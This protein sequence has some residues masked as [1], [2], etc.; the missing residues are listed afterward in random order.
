MSTLVNLDPALG[1]TTSDTWDPPPHIEY[2][3]QSN[4]GS[5]GLSGTPF[6]GGYTI[7]MP[8]SSNAFVTLETDVWVNYWSQ[9]D[10]CDF[11]DIGSGHVKVLDPS[12]WAITFSGPVGFFTESTSTLPTIVTVEF[13][14]WKDPYITCGSAGPDVVT[15]INAAVV[16]F[17]GVTKQTL[18]QQQTQTFEAAVGPN[19]NP[20]EINRQC[21]LQNAAF[22]L[23]DGNGN[24]VQRFS[25]DNPTYILQ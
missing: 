25:L 13:S 3:R 16:K 6:Q 22:I 14:T 5:G 15:N 9:N 8:T 7:T 11:C 21:T 4:G 23:K 10:Q 19:P 18:V 1:L 20:Y 2:G 17:D 12:P 24:E